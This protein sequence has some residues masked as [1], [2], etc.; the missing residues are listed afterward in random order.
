MKGYYDKSLELYR[1]QAI[2]AAEDLLY[3]KKY[4]DKLYTA[5]SE[6]EIERIM[7][8]ARHASY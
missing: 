5:K 2:D 1:K 6:A 3:A 4:V 8:D 7:K